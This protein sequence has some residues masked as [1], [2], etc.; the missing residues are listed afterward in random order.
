MAFPTNVYVG[1]SGWTYPDWIGSFYP[2]DSK[3]QD[4]IQHYARAFRAVELDSTYSTIPAR[5]VRGRM[6]GKHSSG[7][8]F[9]GPGARSHYAPESD[10][11]LPARAHDVFK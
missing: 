1:T 8:C 11:G 4:L 5:A 9:C 6:E 3:P 10:E 7:I 2:A